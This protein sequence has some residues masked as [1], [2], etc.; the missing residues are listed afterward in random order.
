MSEEKN[1][2][3]YI[4]R[5]VRYKSNTTNNETWIGFIRTS[6]PDDDGDIE[7]NGCKHE[8]K[9]IEIIESLNIEM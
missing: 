6:T 3:N 5:V 4:E 2:D 8:L 7:I 1:I 9:S